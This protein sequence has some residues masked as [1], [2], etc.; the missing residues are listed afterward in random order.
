MSRIICC[1]CACDAVGAGGAVGMG[2]A[3]VVGVVVEGARVVGVVVTVTVSGGAVVGG[4]GITAPGGRQMSSPGKIGVSRVARLASISCAGV[5][6]A[7][8]AMRYHES[9]APASYVS[10]HTGSTRSAG[11]SAVAASSTAD[12][13]S[14][15]TTCAEVAGS[16][17]GATAAVT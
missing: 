9:P 4:G 13:A 2:A 1:T 5:M 16:A 14:E 10:E 6:P 8:S 15:V 17:T 12:G 7:P 11:C 3:V